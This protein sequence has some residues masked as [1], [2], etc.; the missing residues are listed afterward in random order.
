VHCNMRTGRRED[1]RSRQLTGVIL[2]PLAIMAVAINQRPALVAVAPLVE[3]LRAD[4]ALSSAVAGL[5]TTLPV[6]CFAFFAPVTPHVQRRIG[7]ERAIG[8]SLIV[9]AAGIALRLLTPLALLFAGSLLVGAAIAISNV[10][11]P[12]FI[13]RTFPRPGAMMG[14]YTAA[15]SL[16]AAA[17]G[18]ATVPIA[19]AWGLSWRGAL[20]LWLP[21]ALL[22]FLL[23]LPMLRPVVSRP[24]AVAGEP[25][26]HGGAWWML[27]IPLARHVT[28]YFGV[29]SAVFYSF[30]AWLPA[31][32]VDSGTSVQTA[33]LLLGLYNI[34]GAVGAFAAPV[35]A[36]RMRTQHPLLLAVVAGFA[37]GLVG[38]LVSPDRGTVAW[39]CVFGVAQGAGF[40]LALTFTVLRS[41]TPEVAAR[42][43]GVAQALGYLL[44]ASGPLA[45][46]AIHDLTGRWPWALV[47]LL[48]MLLPMTWAGWGAAGDRTLGEPSRTPSEH[49]TPHP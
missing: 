35:L 12:A 19:E 7:L 45:L 8:L 42:L 37:V 27:R 48:L 13:K 41:A 30:S 39:I 1:H 16:G 22:A 29:Q 10:L 9:L 6:L 33:G 5:L 36:G 32:L 31:L 4:T 34:A 44:A 23:W 26:S 43:G 49:S 24:T 28:V 21:I 47:L 40:A 2:L 25:R 38:L 17:A 20:A 14:C 18:G 11:M 46:G 3:E 15:M